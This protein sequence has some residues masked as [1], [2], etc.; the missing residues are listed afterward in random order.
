MVFP[1]LRPG[2]EGAAQDC[3]GFAG[4]VRWAALVQPQ[5]TPAAPSRRALAPVPAAG[6]VPPGRSLPR[7]LPQAG[8]LKSSWD[9]AA[10]RDVPRCSEHQRCSGGPPQEPRRLSC[11]WLCLPVLLLP[12]CILQAHSDVR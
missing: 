8:D 12:V 2:C 9:T 7:L 1:W 10:I 5:E 6:L 4:R 3:E 11:P